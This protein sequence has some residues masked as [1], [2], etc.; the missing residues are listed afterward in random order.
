MN[1]LLLADFDPQGG[2]GTYFNRIV[3]YL[4]KKGSVHIVFDKNQANSIDIDFLRKNNVNWS[5][6][7]YRLPKIEN[8]IMRIFRRLNLVHI[9]CYVRDYL[10]MKK[11]LNI[12]RPDFIFI[13]QG[14]GTKYFCFLRT[15][16]PTAIICHSLFD[17]KT[18]DKP[19]YHFYNSLLGKNIDTNSKKILMV[20]EYAKNLFL[21]KMPPNFRQIT[22]TVHNCTNITSIVSDAH[23]ITDEVIVL[24]LGHLIGY[25]NP[26]V[27]LKTAKLVNERSKTPIKFLWAGKP[28][29]WGHYKEEFEENKN[30]SFLGYTKDTESLYNKACIYF[31][32]SIL[33]NHSIAVVEALAH[34]IPCV[35]SNIGGLPESVINGKNGFIRN[36]NDAEG[37]AECILSL[38]NNKEIRD[39]MGLEAI[40]IYKE[41]FTENS[42]KKNM[43]NIIA[44][45]T[46]QE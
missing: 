18:E 31:Q 37:F 36:V 27:W 17:E 44:S 4:S 33:E 8:I 10:V 42:W 46:P 28:V 1:I 14:G 34:G 16:I 2:T 38:I 3:P 15:H 9:Y 25:K 35:V 43:D 23:S 20:S 30:V 12:Y 5:K 6:N 24:T 26:D 45:C 21:S 7:L 32:P 22:F 41:N 13:S 11:L 19:F 39:K 40:K 29:D